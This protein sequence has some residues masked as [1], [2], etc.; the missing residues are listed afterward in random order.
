VRDDERLAFVIGVFVACFVMSLAMAF[1]VN[2]ENGAWRQQAI[3]HGAARYNA[4]SG[5]F[6]WTADAVSK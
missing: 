1:A 5:E 3:D 4:T 2:Q 6:E